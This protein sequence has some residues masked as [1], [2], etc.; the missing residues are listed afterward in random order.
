MLLP[1][2]VVLATAHS[3]E[4]EP[5]GTGKDQPVIWVNRYGKG[6]VFHNVLSHDVQAMADAM[7]QEWMRRGVIWAAGR[8]A[9]PT[10]DFTSLNS[11][12]SGAGSRAIAVGSPSQIRKSPANE[13]AASKAAETNRSPDASGQ[14]Y[15]RD[16]DRERTRVP[17]HQTR[18]WVVAHARPDVYSSLHRLALGQ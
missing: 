10:T 6:R 2:S 8:A 16:N 5:R 9:S 14:E 12:N 7:F 13:P 15:G 17:R 11:A 3:D 18:K 4:S 1:G